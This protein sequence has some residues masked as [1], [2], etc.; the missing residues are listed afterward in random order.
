MDS[1][2]FN[3]FANI[4]GRGIGVL[5][6][7]DTIKSGGLGSYLM[8]RQRLMGDP[9]FRASLAGSPFSAGI[10]GVSGTT[11][12]APAPPGALPATGAGGVVQPAEM[13]G[14]PPPGVQVAAPGE[15]PAVTAYNVPGYMPGQPRA[16]MPNLPP[17]DPEEALK[18]QAFASQQ[19]A[20]AGGSDVQ[21]GL[22]KTAVGIMPTQ[23]ESQAVLRQA[24]DIQRQAGAGSTVGVKFPG[25][26]VQIGSPYSIAPLGEEEFPTPEQARQAADAH[27]AGLP[28]GSAHW[29]VGPTVHG[30]WKPVPPP[31]GA[32]LLPPPPGGGGLPTYPTGPVT[33]G[34]VKPPPLSR[35]SYQPNAFVQGMVNR[36]WT[37]DEA[38]AAAG[39]AHIESGFIPG[40]V[41]P[42][43][44]S[45]LIQWAGP[46]LAGLQ[47]YA[48]T[49]GRSWKDAEAQ[50]DWL[51]MERSGE[52]TKWGGSDE[53]DSFRKAFDA[54][55]TPQEMAG[56]FGQFVERPRDL[57]ATVDQRM[58]AAGLYAPA[59]PP[60]TQVAT[61]PPPAPSPAGGRGVA[62]AAEPPPGAPV[63]T[64]PPP[65]APAPTFDREAVV[66]H[67]VV[68]DS[69]V[70]YPSPAPAEE[71]GP[72]PPPTV[73]P[74]ITVRPPVAATPLAPVAPPPPAPVWPG[75]P[76]DPATGMP[77][78]G[79]TQ[80]YQGGRTETYRA[81]E[82][83]TFEQQ[84][85]AR[86][87][88]I[89]D[90]SLIRDPQTVVNYFNWKQNVDDQAKIHTADIE[91]MYAAAGPAQVAAV[92][93]LNQIQGTINH[94]LE[95]YSPDQIEY[96]VGMLR[97]PAHIVQQMLGV[98]WADKIAQFRTDIAPIAPSTFETDAK[99][100]ILTGTELGYLSPLAL[101]PRDEASQFKTNLQ[102]LNDGVRR[103]LAF[104]DYIQHVPPD[105]VANPTV[106]QQF[107][108]DFDRQL[109]EQRLAA[110]GAPLP[111]PPPAPAPPP[112]TTP[113][114]PP[115][116]APRSSAWA[117]TSTWVL[118]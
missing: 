100:N 118:R 89:T 19:Q 39:N 55:G 94:I 114:P 44:D 57:S 108:Q 107:N 86:Y 113:P 76:H 53:R 22:A 14:P 79:R 24:A 41:A 78:A 111:A 90:P 103:A 109:A 63:F 47:S 35:G 13:V 59:A 36:G 54:G 58:A 73:P 29:T 104:R 34:T 67:V 51:A 38:A 46:R 115:A 1:P 65:P 7:L 84:M 116:E 83:G 71:R 96:Y 88:G 62:F 23:A 102:G 91:R 43:G 5:A 87:L 61:T 95:T 74:P 6:A 80:E 2:A 33:Q 4:A 40:N 99:N 105:Q 11:G 17:Y 45:G 106:L 117:P 52:S 21:R 10:F 69:Q 72:G 92:Q 97:Y 50:M 66:P 9:G 112:P 18:Q 26:T 27:N 49:T 28:A 56:R 81:P 12:P 110:A 8:N 31:T 70:G 16:W 15:L 64:P 20:V 98:S 37:G 42:G 82:L 48:S 30:G 68:P 25:M 60:A 32:Q 101:N 3:S 77:I 85:M 93:R 75:T